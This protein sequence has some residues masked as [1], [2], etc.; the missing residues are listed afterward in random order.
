M[1]DDYDPL[2]VV[3]EAL[4]AH[5]CLV[6]ERNGKAMAQC[7]AHA[8][9]TPSLSITTGDDGRVLL[10][11]FGDCTVAAVLEALELEMH[12]L[13]ADGDGEWEPGEQRYEIPTVADNPISKLY[14]Y[15]DANGT[16]VA[17]HRR[18]FEDGKKKRTSGHYDASGKAQPNVPEDLIVPLFHADVIETCTDTEVVWVTEGERDADNLHKHLTIAWMAPH[19][20]VTTT[21][22]GASRPLIDEWITP[23]KKFDRVFVVVDCNEA[24]WKRPGVARH[25]SAGHHP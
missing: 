4:A 13:F 14:N 8:D 7:P 24:G 15:V 6:T 12:Q 1:A 5:D 17:Y 10:W 16:K 3:L 11:C 23:L 9:S 25:R 20:P 18:H 19:I 2:E 22:G 21:F